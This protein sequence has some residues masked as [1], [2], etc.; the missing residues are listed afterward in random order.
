[1]EK[2]KL[3][4]ATGLHTG[5]WR[6]RCFGFLRAGTY[7]SLLGV[8]LSLGT[9]QVDA[10]VSGGIPFLFFI[11]A[12]VLYAAGIW[13]IPYA[14][15]R[16]GKRRD[17]KR[18]WKTHDQNEIVID[19][20]VAMFAVYAPLTFL[21]YESFWFWIAVVVGLAVFRITDALKFWPAHRYDDRKDPESVMDDDLSVA[22]LYGLPAVVVVWVVEWCLA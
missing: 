9:L 20:I 22:F 11:F 7:G 2:L 16:L 1:M 12:V 8:V 3:A 18:Q 13:S 4:I 19:E 21:R 10:A 14:E 15:K 17:H 5:L 6:P